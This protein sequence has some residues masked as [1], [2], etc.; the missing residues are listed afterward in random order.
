MHPR[1][2]RVLIVAGAAAALAGTGVAVA[3]SGGSDESGGP[4]AAA[5]PARSYVADDEGRRGNRPS[6]DDH[7]DD[8]AKRIGV[9][10][11]KLDDALREQSLA[12]VDWARSAGF[13]SQEEADDL[14]EA[15]E[16][17]GGR[18]F[19]FGFG[20]AGGFAFGLG[21]GKIGGV[22]AAE[23]AAAAQLLGLTVTQL[24]NELEEKTLA[25]VASEKGKSV[26]ELKQKLREARKEAVDDAVADKDLTQQQADA[27]L[28]RYDEDLDDIVNGRSPHITDLAE[29]LGV[30][31]GKVADAL[32]A[33][34]LA[35]I[36]RA[37]D[38]GFL[39][40]EDADR[41]KKRIEE[42]PAEAF[43]FGGFGPGGPGF[44]CP[45]GF[46]K[47]RGGFSFRG[48]DGDFELRGKPGETRIK[49]GAAPRELR[50]KI[51]EPVVPSIFS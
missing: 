4:S 8:L 11:S 36:D 34:R 33:S 44:L 14:K 10:R 30:D 17:G 2:P 3:A 25:Q 22:G 7:L 28:K 13:L 9:E 26:D 12:E 35:G 37:V 20:K 39:D 23:H 29:R 15:I 38:D 1:S 27:L 19:G 47:G 48:K 31:R 24:G 50:E 21:F 6:R 42:A 41:L 46:E 32:K 51:P 43:G 16:D 49:P 5:A 40:R 18:H 45:P